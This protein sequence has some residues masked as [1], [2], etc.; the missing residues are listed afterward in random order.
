[1]NEPIDKIPNPA[2][3]GAPVISDEQYNKWLD[4]MRPFLR[5]GS[6]LFYS[7]DKAGL[8]THKDSIYKKFKQN[9]WFSERINAL[10]ATV[11]EM[12]N[13]V[14]FMVV[15][16]VKTRLVETDGKTELSQ[17]EVTVWKTMAEK[18]RSAQ[19]FFVTRTEEAKAD[20][21]KLGKIIDNLDQGADYDDLATEA[22][23]QVV[24]TN[25]P[26][27]DQGQTGENGNVQAQPDPN[28]VHNP[29]A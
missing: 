15:E 5:R 21:T 8:Y 26:V 25:P 12:I 2:G 28:Q 11:G 18:H 3:N 13:D 17:Q 4:D 29:T 22:Q 10:R 6:T 16:K 23:Q 27:Q 1:M 19:P 14:G 9:D 7:L 20:D 24:A